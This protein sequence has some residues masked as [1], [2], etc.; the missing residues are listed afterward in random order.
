M[1]VASE[2]SGGKKTV[3]LSGNVKVNT[4]W[5]AVNLCENRGD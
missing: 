4:L 5:D 2:E 3:M 1:T